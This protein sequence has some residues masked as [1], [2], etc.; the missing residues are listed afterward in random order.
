MNYYLV[1]FLSFMVAIPAMIGAVRFKKILP[2]FRPFIIF[3]WLGLLSEIISTLLPAIAGSNA[4]NSNI[5]V[6]VEGLILL[7]CFYFWSFR[8]RRTLTLYGI[9]AVIFILLWI[10]DNLI[11]NDLTRFNSIY[12]IAYS[13]VIVLMAVDQ[14]N[15]VLME[16]RGIMVRNAIFIICLAFIY[17]YIYRM[18]F[19]VFYIYDFK[20]TPE[21]YNNLFFILVVM[22]LICNLIYAAATLCIPTKQRF[23]LPY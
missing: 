10:F 8:S 1:L 6:L 22:N 3:I 5:Y 21:F 16:E 18:V 7:V 20:M 17:F 15:K 13:F 19:E 9:I 4:V 2:S 12:R 14:M 23:T 11:L